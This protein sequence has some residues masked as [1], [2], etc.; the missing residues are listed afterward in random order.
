MVHQGER[1]DEQ[2]MQSTAG[3]D[4]AAFEI[5]VT[6]YERRIVSYAWRILGELELA[7]DVHQQTFLK[8]FEHRESYRQ[9]ARF[10]TYAYSIAHR[11]CLN[12]LRRAERK[13]TSSYDQ[14]AAASGGDEDSGGGIDHWYADPG[15]DPIEPIEVKER[16]R[17][18]HEA[19]ERLDPAQREIIALRIFEGLPFRDIAEIVQTNEST[20]KSRLRYALGHLDRALRGQIGPQ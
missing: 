5:L 2:L 3:G 12:E 20:I 10:S 11:L 4:L 17:L 14:S 6:R 7:R 9:Q 19:L 1:S 13:Y 16:N 18:L 8:I 15:P